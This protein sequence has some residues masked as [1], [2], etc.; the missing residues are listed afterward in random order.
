M[1]RINLADYAPAQFERG[2]PG[3]IVDNNTATIFNCTN[4]G[5]T[6]IDFGIAVFYT[7]V[8]GEYVLPG[9][10]RATKF[11]GISVRHVTFTANLEGEVFYKPDVTLP[12]L[13]AGRIWATCTDG[14]NPQDPVKFAADGMLA[15][16]KGTQIAGAEW[17]TKTEPGQ[18][19]VVVINRVP[20]LTVPV[21]APD[22]KGK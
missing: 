6:P 8:A 21:A 15:A 10:A 7:D 1:N 19:G 4:R 3:L 2:I 14:C 22:T 13:Q 18:V 16:G 20:G 5:T 11:A 9:D 17:E 12:A